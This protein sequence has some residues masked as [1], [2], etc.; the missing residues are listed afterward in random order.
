MI[1]LFVGLTLVN[2]IGL[3][4]TTA[5]GYSSLRS[6]GEIKPA[7]IL[8][9]A[10]ATLA[11]CGVHCVAFT[12]FIATA[13][14][15]QHAVLV[16]RLDPALAAPTRSF[17]RQA[18]PAA[19]AAMAIV[20]ATAVLGAARDNYGIPRIWHHAFA[21]VALAVNVG[22]AI[23]EYRAIARNGL[24][25]D[26]ILATIARQPQPPEALTPAPAPGNILPPQP[27]PR[28]PPP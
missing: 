2:L 21:L 22:V 1:P 27:T 14:W 15:V 28:M 20:F 26:S 11:C 7:H 4:V 12:Y 13:K 23:V 18:F 8:A 10:L 16:K 6:G 24:L 5:L 9:G 25:I 17:K 3:G 19:L